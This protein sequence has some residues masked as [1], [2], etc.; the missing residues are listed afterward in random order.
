MKKFFFLVAIV[1]FLAANDSF[2]AS[3][4]GIPGIKA[5]SKGFLISCPVG[6]PNVNVVATAVSSKGQ[7]MGSKVYTDKS[8]VVQVPAEALCRP[9]TKVNVTCFVVSNNRILSHSQTVSFI[10]R[11][12]CG[13]N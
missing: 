11:E 1:S 5:N 8:H 4:R 3:G 10:P 7:N 12:Q 9:V 6:G 13:H 2:A